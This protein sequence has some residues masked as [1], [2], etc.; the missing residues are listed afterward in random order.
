LPY[1]VNFFTQAVALATLAEPRILREAVALLVRE[2][3]RLFA[4]LERLPGIKPYPSRANFILVELTSLDPRAVFEALAERG[5]LVRNVSSYPRL[6]R[7][8]RISV[9]SVEE[10]ATL[11]AALGEILSS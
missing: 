6:S 10:N 2:R 9:G 5:V 1:N 11:L 8:L 7:C 3:E 4:A